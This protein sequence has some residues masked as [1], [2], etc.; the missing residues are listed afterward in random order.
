MEEREWSG[1]AT[2]VA[3]APVR[4]ADVGGWTDTWFGSPGRVCN[5]AVRPGVVVEARTVERDGR[6]EPVHL[7]APAVGADLLIGPHPDPSVGWATPTPGRHPLLEHAVAAVLSEGT[8]P[9]ELAIDVEI[10]STVPPGA[11]MGT[12]AAVVVAL[13]AALDRL[14][15]DGTLTSDPARLAVFAHEVEVMRAGREAGVQDHWAAA[16]GG[17]A[18]LSVNPYPSVT[19]RA[20][21]VAEEVIAELDARLVTV[22]FGAHDSADVHARVITDVVACDTI[23]HLRS[24]EALARLSTLAATAADALEAGDL[25]AWAATLTDATETQQS[26][27]ADLVGHDHDRAAALARDHGGLGWKVNGAGGAGGSLTVLAADRTSAEA[28]RSDLA[29]VDPSWTVVDHRFSAD[30][31]TVRREP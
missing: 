3:E 18:L 25:R 2:V 16:A 11:S 4:V 17:A 1:G 10:T 30:G 5:I 28:L 9:A 24:R 19:R 7:V 21:S 23:A 13:L 12:S 6:Y 14:C 27:H 8:V 22:V 20:L 31:V 29:G 26:L 15:A